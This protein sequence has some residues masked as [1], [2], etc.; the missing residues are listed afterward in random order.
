M[1]RIKKLEK[2]SGTSFIVPEDWHYDGFVV[3][4]RMNKTLISMGD[5]IY[6]DI[7][8]KDGVVPRLRCFVYRKVREIY[9]PTTG[10][11]LGYVIRKVGLVEVTREIEEEMCAAR[12][13]TSYEPIAVGYYIRAAVNR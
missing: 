9:H 10:K 12:V 6:L 5:T 4:E 7:G 3:G 2:Y 8:S 1:E 11:F 13:I